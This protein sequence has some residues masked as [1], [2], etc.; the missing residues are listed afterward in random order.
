M[1]ALVAEVVAEM[2]TESPSKMMMRKT[3]AAMAKRSPFLSVALEI[4]SAVLF[5]GI[6]K[7]AVRLV[8]KP[9]LLKA[10]NEDS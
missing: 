6:T 2:K 9:Q 4:V 7:Q 5:Y 10:K 1:T 3:A 8:P